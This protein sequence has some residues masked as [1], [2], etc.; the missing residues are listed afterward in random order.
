MKPAPKLDFSTTYPIVRT[1]GD[2]GDREWDR[3][4]RA[5]RELGIGATHP[6]RERWRGDAL[7]DGRRGIGRRRSAR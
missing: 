4:R 3:E 2:L 7:R 6:A 1:P 5:G